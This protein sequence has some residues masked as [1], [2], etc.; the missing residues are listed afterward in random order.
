MRFKKNPYYV[1]KGISVHMQCM[2]EM[3]RFLYTGG[4]VRQIFGKNQIEIWNLFNDH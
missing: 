3:S 4:N 1:E 2:L